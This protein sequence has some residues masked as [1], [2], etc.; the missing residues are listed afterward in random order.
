MTFNIYKINSIEVCEALNSGVK[1]VV[2][3]LKCP[4]RKL[5]S[6]MSETFQ[7][8]HLSVDLDPGPFFTPGEFTVHLSPKVN[9]AV[10]P[11]ADIIHAIGCEEVTLVTLG[12]SGTAFTSVSFA[13]SPLTA[14]TKGTA[15][16]LHSELL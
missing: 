4:Q 8:P 5:V 15:Y 10:R 1:A 12:V 13:W 2:S 3:A 9:R 6:A 7:I 16:V 11:M 14:F